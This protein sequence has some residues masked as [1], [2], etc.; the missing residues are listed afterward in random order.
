MTKYVGP[1]SAA[2]SFNSVVIG[3]VRDI[4]GP[5]MV[6]DSVDVTTRENSDRVYIPG[7]R[8]G[9]ELTFDVIYDP[10]LATHI[11]LQSFLLAGSVGVAELQLADTANLYEGFRFLAMVSTMTLESPL[12]G[13]LG[14]SITLRSVSQPV[15]I[16]YLVDDLGNYLV[17]ESGNY[18]IS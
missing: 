5:G 4:S 12:E 6:E 9:G 18:L 8:D 17:D 10:N 16:I 3:Q 1:S 15:P 7:L 13:A 2:L 14:A 11:T